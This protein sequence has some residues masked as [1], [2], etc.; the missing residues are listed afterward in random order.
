MV[1]YS[2]NL[3]QRNRVLIIKNDGL[4]D[5]VLAVPIIRALSKICDGRVDIVCKK[6]SSDFLKQEFPTANI[7]I[8]DKDVYFSSPNF[9]YLSLIGKIK[10]CLKYI[11]YRPSRADKSFVYD[12]KSYKY[13][14][15]FVVRRFIRQSTLL[16]MKNINAEIK[17]HSAFYPTNISQLPELQGWLQVGAPKEFVHEF[18]FFR[19]AFRDYIG[20]G[21]LSINLES[22]AFQKSILKKNGVALVLGNP[23]RGLSKEIV[24]KVICY[25]TQFDSELIVN[26]YGGEDTR[27]FL[28]SNK[29]LSFSRVRM[30]AGMLSFRDS[31]KHMIQ[32]NKCAIGN[33]TGFMHLAAYFNLPLLIFVSGET[34]ERFFP[35]PGSNNQTIIR[36]SISC[37]DCIYCAFAERYCMNFTEEDVLCYL[38][39]YMHR[40]LSPGSVM[41]GKHRAVKPLWRW[42]HEL[43]EIKFKN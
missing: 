43:R 3:M 18:I 32:H 14:A 42:S 1:G 20:Q 31:I 26:I 27:E 2:S 33:D 16:L 4:G 5:A 29:F 17:V 37:A 30:L 35:W 8:F 7:F 9:R 12:L 24:E 21:D 41:L 22:K 36:K 34:P 23:K 28:K 11:K 6:V 19:H 39:R 13:R 15:A 38:G 40:E 10:E 25:L